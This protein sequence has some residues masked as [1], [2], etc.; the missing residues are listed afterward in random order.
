MDRHSRRFRIVI[1]TQLLLVGMTILRA[2][3]FTG[4]YRGGSDTCVW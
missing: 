1:R 4:R 2:A 3:G